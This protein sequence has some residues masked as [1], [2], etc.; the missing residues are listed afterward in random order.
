MV[1]VIQANK[2]VPIIPMYIKKCKFEE[3]FFNHR[4]IL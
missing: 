4:I 2:S 1:T 3:P